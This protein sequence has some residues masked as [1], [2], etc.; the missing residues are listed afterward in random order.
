MKILWLTAV[1]VSALIFAG[2]LVIQTPQ[3]QTFLAGKIL[4]KLSENIDADIRFE[5]IHIKPFNTLILKNAE[6]LDK[7]PYQGASDTLFKAEYV[8][9]RFTLRGLTEDE[10]LHI[11]RAYIRN[12]RM[13][14]V[15]E[16]DMT[17]LKEY[18]R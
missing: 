5:R 9:A 13:D 3:V 8:I 1:A 18:S 14:M 7:N 17:N 15:I 11:G 2:L 4:E 6:I 10:G 12:A 16:E